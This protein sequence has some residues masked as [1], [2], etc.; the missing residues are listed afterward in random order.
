MQVPGVVSRNSEHLMDQVSKVLRGDAM[1]L[2]FYDCAN[3]YCETAIDD[4][5]GVEHRLR[6]HL[7]RILVQRGVDLQHIKARL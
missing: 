3:F 6:R 7:S 1:T 4:G 2:I 5:E